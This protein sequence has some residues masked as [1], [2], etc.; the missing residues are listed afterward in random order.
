MN[1]YTWK[2]FHSIVEIICQRGD[3]KVLLEQALLEI[4]SINE[5]DIPL[6]F[7]E[8]VNALKRNLL[9]P[10]NVQMISRAN[11]ASCLIQNLTEDEVDDI[12]HAI[13]ELE[14]LM[15]PN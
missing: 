11:Y 4:S 13:C 3:K 15:N 1:Y 7:R 8:Q 10:K 6:K 9:P 2:K 5:I 12:F 14:S